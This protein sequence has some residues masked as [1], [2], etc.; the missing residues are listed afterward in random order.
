MV[1]GIPNDSFMKGIAENLP[2]FWIAA[3]P[4]QIDETTLKP[5]ATLFRG[6]PE[7]IY[8]TLLKEK[9]ILRLKIN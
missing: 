1:D 6:A 7:K 5:L 8:L 3:S 4:R 9:Q 2:R